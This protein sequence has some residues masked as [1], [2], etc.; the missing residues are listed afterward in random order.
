MFVKERAGIKKALVDVGYLSVQNEYIPTIEYIFTTDV[1]IR[2]KT[3]K[4]I[5]M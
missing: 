1:Q 5:W 3:G 4:I 2:R